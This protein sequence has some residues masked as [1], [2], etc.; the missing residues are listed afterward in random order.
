VEVAE[1]IGFLTDP[2]P[3]YEFAA[4]EAL[5]DIG[6]PA[7]AALAEGLRGEELLQVRCAHALRRIGAPALTALVAAAA[8]AD[9]DVSGRASWALAELEATDAQQYLPLLAHGS[10]S[11]RTAAAQRL[12]AEATRPEVSQQYLPGLVSLLNDSDAEVRHTAVHALAAYGTHALPALRHQ[13]QH[14][15][16]APGR[17]AALQAIVATAGWDGLDPTDQTVIGRL[18]TIK[19]ATE[20]AE[21]FDPRQWIAVRTHDQAALLDALGITAS[22]PVTMRLGLSAYR[23]HRDEARVFVSPVLDGWIIVLDPTLHSPWNHPAD[24]TDLTDRLNVLSRRFGAAHYY[25]E[26]MAGG[27][28]IITADGTAVC[29]CD[30][31]GQLF[32]WPG[33]PIDHASLP[34]GGIWLYDVVRKVSVIPDEL[35]PH[36]HLDGH[37]VLATS[38][39]GHDSGLPRGCLQI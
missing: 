16:T 4:E 9:P 10:P 29:S 18:I 31:C 37:A 30:D 38:R 17:R 20:V 2:R 3:G 8:D 5:V 22:V 13:R 7:V 21:P 11:V 27:D 14:A 12:G 6:A 34:D 33:C 35:G 39:H 23:A 24:L 28:W 26:G 1:L 36:T 19:L 15:S 25:H 32:C